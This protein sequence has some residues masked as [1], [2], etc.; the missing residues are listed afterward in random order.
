MSTGTQYPQGAFGSNT[1]NLSGLQIIHDAFPNF[2]TADPN[3]DGVHAAHLVPYFGV[4]SGGLAALAKDNRRR[5]RFQLPD[6]YLGKSAMLAERILGLAY[7]LQGWTYSEPDGLPMAVADSLTIEWNWWK[8]DEGYLEQEPEEGSAREMSAGVQAQSATMLRRSKGIQLEHGFW[9]T[10]MGQRHYVR[11]VQQLSNT[12]YNTMSMDVLI[13]ML[14]VRP[15]HIDNMNSRVHSD[16]PYSEIVDIQAQNFARWQK[17]GRAAQKTVSEYK[18]ILEDRGKAPEMMV[19]PRGVETFLRGANNAPEL[20][21]NVVG[22]VAEQRQS[23]NPES[24]RRFEGMRV[25][26]TRKYLNAVGGQLP[27]DPLVNPV[28]MF[29]E[30]AQMAPLS[31][32]SRFSQTDKYKT[33]DRDI[34]MPNYRIDNWQRLTLK[35]AINM[36][37]FESRG[38]EESEYLRG[39]AMGNNFDS[40]VVAG[41]RY[42]QSPFHCQGAGGK[43]VRAQALGQVQEEFLSNEAFKLMVKQIVA[44]GVFATLGVNTVVNVA[45]LPVVEAFMRRAATRYPSPAATFTA[46]QPEAIANT[47]VYQKAYYGA[48]MKRDRDMVDESSIDNKVYYGVFVGS[49]IEKQARTSGADDTSDITSVI[50]RVTAVLSGD[51]ASH[52][53][54]FMRELDPAA[55]EAFHRRADSIIASKDTDVINSQLLQPLSQLQEIAKSNLTKTEKTNRAQELKTLLVTSNEKAATLSAGLKQPP[56]SA[57]ARL[58]TDSEVAERRANGEVFE[59]K[60]DFQITGVDSFLKFLGH[61]STESLSYGASMTTTV[62]DAAF[63]TIKQEMKEDVDRRYA[64]IK[65]DGLGEQLTAMALL[66]QKINRKLFNLLADN[67]IYF[68]F[69]LVI[70]RPWVVVTTNTVIIGTGGKSLGNTYYKDAD[71]MLQD[72]ATSKTHLAHFTIY[73]KAVIYAPELL[74]IVD[75]VAVSRYVGG[76]TVDLLTKEHMDEIRSHNFKIPVQDVRGSVFVLIA[77]MPDG[78]RLPH[79][80]NLAGRYGESDDNGDELPEW[81]YHR[82]HYAIEAILAGPRPTDLFKFQSPGS[83]TPDNYMNWSMMQVPQLCVNPETGRMTAVIKCESNHMGLWYPGAVH[84]MQKL[85]DILDDYG[86]NDITKFQDYFTFN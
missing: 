16:K 32:T 71:V 72:D 41:A 7:D 49:S 42:P 6:A 28:R 55:Q 53:S 65:T 75:D 22:L 1:M 19:I 61:A 29:G 15:A 26:H 45:G 77:A 74:A 63:P 58:Y 76:G 80:L 9:K 47:T 52:Y 85:T 11:Q 50:S 62:P 34:M 40:S 57:I 17:T 25:H 48:S 82:E 4:P 5:N 86:Y 20:D 3:G 39:H 2:A 37:D 43:V 69:T 64:L 79:K 56:Q 81:F 46:R 18:A 44:K 13:T 10:A 23:V 68:P 8:F 59:S 67:D 33:A 27:M 70:C 21:V 78:Q 66:L 14:N 12:L 60:D 83:K 51:S 24:I 54:S 38:G 30:F 84:Q 73:L 31:A 36:M 35:Q